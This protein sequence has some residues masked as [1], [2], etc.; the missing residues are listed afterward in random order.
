MPRRKPI[1]KRAI[2]P[3][4]QQT[5]NRDTGNDGSP[6]WILV[7]VFFLAL[8]LRLAH[9]WQLRDSPFSSLLIGD[10][11]QYHQWAQRIAAGDWWGGG[12][13]YQAPLY[14]YVLAALYVTAGP[15]IAVVKI[16]QAILGSLACVLIAL[17]G[18]RL[19]GRRAGLLAGGLLA[20]YG[21]AMFFDGLVQKS[22]LDL[23]VL[24]GFLLWVALLGQRV[25]IQRAIGAGIC[26]GCLGLTRENTLV[27]LPVILAWLWSRQ[28]SFRPLIALTL[29]MFVVLAPVTLR[30]YAL[31]GELHLTTA[32]LGPNL[33]IGNSDR[34]TGIYVPLRS[35]S[36]NAASEQQDATDIAQDALGRQLS[37]GDV[38]RYWQQRALTW[39]EA[40][41]AAWVRLTA[42]KLFMVWNA[43]EATDTEDL[44][45]HAEWS[46]P[47]RATALFHFG[48][49]APLGLVGMWLTRDQWRRY[50]VLPALCIAYTI[51]VA[52]FYVLARYR[53]PL[54]PILILCAGAALARFPDWWSRADAKEKWSVG[55]L[56]ATVTVLINWPILS[57]A[58]MRAITHYNLGR[59]LQ[60][61]AHAE[62]AI[63]EYRKAI[64]LA[65][66]YAPAHS[67]LG[68]LLV[69]SGDR[70]TAQAEFE[71]ALRL[72][73]RLTEAHVNLGIEFAAAGRNVEA[74]E[75]FTRALALEPRSA[76]AHYN[77]GIAYATLGRSD[78]ARTQFEETLRLEPTNAVA[79]NNLGVL[80]AS[81][82]QISEAID[83]F[84]KAV[85]LRPDYREAAENLKRAQELTS[86][87]P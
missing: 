28:H 27:L 38:S 7:A 83:H 75:E 53:Y 42:K 63:A 52:L 62:Q 45:T 73:P 19:F 39:I 5:R 76:V 70:A 46:W 25:T 66:D 22:T 86:A 85:A 9:L 18:V 17:A 44:Y 29:A 26:L 16:A 59:E 49:L 3:P 64:E 8:I 1:G 37:P 41:P 65:P 12:V 15:S 54:V 72:D 56:T 34:A 40:N 32:Q 57:T 71:Q 14:P 11:L 47:L 6:G 80:A 48:V 67:N 36:G 31:S 81:S 33:Y 74:I 50:W 82:G 87:R 58:E 24:S 30:N 77:L 4:D 2:A 23:F 78:D 20:I 61:S 21:P 60:D 69:A 68:T 13:F 55:I 51:S 10:A 84:K 43:T 79:H 35:G